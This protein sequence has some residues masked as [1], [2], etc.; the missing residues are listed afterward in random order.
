[1]AKYP[2]SFCQCCLQNKNDL[3]CVLLINAVD[4]ENET[5]FYDISKGGSTHTVNNLNDGV[6]E[7]IS[8]NKFGDTS[9]Y[10]NGSTNLNIDNSSDFNFGTDDFILDFW[11]YNSET[12][13]SNSV[14]VGW[15]GAL[16]TNKSILGIKP[17][18]GG[19]VYADI[20]DFGVDSFSY[21]SGDDYRNGWYLLTLERYAGYL[22]F[23]IDD[24]ILYSKEVNTSMNV[25][26]N[27]SN[28][29]KFTIGCQKDS[30]SGSNSNY[31]T[32]YI[33]SFRVTKGVARR[34]NYDFVMP[35]DRFM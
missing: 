25:S 18:S 3:D 34:K 10:F 5:S 2:M 20:L 26:F 17:N 6:I 4:S 27:P 35:T 15:A 21:E 8:Q 32:G 11:F 13:S 16:G 12:V 29:K 28:D 14:F 1:M 23:Y 9:A 19:I 7:S 31:Y 30:V 24:N 33:D 22:K